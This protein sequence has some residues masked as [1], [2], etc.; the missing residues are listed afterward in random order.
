MQRFIPALALLCAAATAF[1]E[2]CNGE[3]ELLFLRDQLIETSEGHETYTD[4]YSIRAD[5]SGERRLS[6]GANAEPRHD[7]T[8]AAWSPDGRHIVFVSNRDGDE[9]PEI[10]RMAVDGSQLQRLT[11]QQGYDEYPDWSRRGEI[12]FSSNR[13]GQDFQLFV[14][15]EQGKSGSKLTDSGDKDF[16]ARWSP[17]GGAYV[18]T[19]EHAGNYRVLLGR[20]GEPAPTPL[21]PA[22]LNASEAAWTP[23][24]ERLIFVSD[25]HA[26]GSGHLELFIMNARDSDRDGIGDHL[27]R[28]SNTPPDTENMEPDLSRDGRC[29]LFVRAQPDNTDKSDIYVMPFAGGEAVRI[30]SGF[31]PR[32]R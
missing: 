10:Y 24:G 19:R 6:N 16:D 20:R 3:R 18:F 5:A 26:P 21:S 17:D 29:L 30:T 8:D 13:D 28:L 11:E 14:M 1:A 15:D 7:N 12:I 27:Q 23:D 25:G 22:W 32:W 9:N 2:P 4:I 31:A